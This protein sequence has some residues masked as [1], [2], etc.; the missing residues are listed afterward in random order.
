MALGYFLAEMNMSNGDML[1]MLINADE[2]WGKFAKRSDQLVRLMEIVT[3]AR[4]KYPF[5]VIPESKEQPIQGMG[6]VEILEAEIKVEWSW[7]GLYQKAGYFLLTGPTGVGK[8]QFSTNFAAK[9]AMGQN[10]LDREIAA[11]SKVGLFS[12]EMGLAEIKYFLEKQIAVYSKEELLTL[13]EMFKVVPLG[14]PLYLNQ[15]REK[16]RVE[17]Y[18]EREELELV[19][20]D[21]LGSITDEELSNETSIKG[22][23]DW[24][25]RL[26]QFYGCGI[27]LIHHHRKAQAQNKKPNKLSDVYGSQYITARASTVMALWDVGSAIQ[28]IPLK[29][30]LAIKPHP[31]YIYRDDKL[32]FSLSKHTVIEDTVN[33]DLTEVEESDK[34]DIDVTD[35]EMENGPMKF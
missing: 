19:I 15:N 8:T 3:R 12:L 17:E 14:E 28:A 21:S 16:L 25:D 27:W 7:K 23:M 22:L 32:N 18:I 20:F 26:R 5:K 6:I 2:R 34:V 35:A 29:V 9:L 1:A 33:E 13:Q 10:F 24:F 11:P 30:R 4:L 31:F